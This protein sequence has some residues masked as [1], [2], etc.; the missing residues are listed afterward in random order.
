MTYLRSLPHDD[1][2]APREGEGISEEGLR[3][4]KLP[5]GNTYLTIAFIIV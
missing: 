3:P 4:F 5:L 2:Y 1:L